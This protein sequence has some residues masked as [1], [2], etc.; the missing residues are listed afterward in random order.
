[1]YHQINHPL[2]LYITHS[3]SASQR[4]NWLVTHRRLS[5]EALAL[6]LPVEEAELDALLVD[7]DDELEEPLPEDVDVPDAEP[8]AELVDVLLDEALELE[9]PVEEALL[10]ALLAPGS[11]QQPCHLKR[12]AVLLLIMSSWMPA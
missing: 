9:L 7:V 1:L 12:P 2:S 5:I 3:L 8:D 6:E 10:E 4:N 11:H